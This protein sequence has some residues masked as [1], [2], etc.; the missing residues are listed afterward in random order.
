MLLRPRLLEKAAVDTMLSAF[1][2]SN[3]ARLRLRAVRSG[4]WFRALVRIDRVL[5]DLALRVVPRIQSRALIAA[6]TT[7]VEK[8]ESTLGNPFSLL[9]D[10]VGFQLAHRLSLIGE[11]LGNVSA[12]TW[13]SDYCFAR[14]LAVM[15]LNNP[16]TGRI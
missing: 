9:V 10:E 7:V 3:L 13:A 1:S 5:V 11:K 8:L 4:A 16:K 14:F 15:H 12:R 2:K 6:L